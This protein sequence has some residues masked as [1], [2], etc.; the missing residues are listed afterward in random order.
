MKKRLFAILLC[1]AIPC[2]AAPLTVDIL[3]DFE[4]STDG[5]D[6]TDAIMAAA[7][8]GSIGAGVWHTMSDPEALTQGTTPYLEITTAAK[9]PIYTPFTVDGITYPA[10]GTRGLRA[11][12]SDNNTVCYFFDT[13]YPT[14]LSVGFFFRFNGPAINSSPRDLLS[15]VDGGG[16][17]QALQIYDQSSGNPY[18]HAHTGLGAGSDIEFLRAHWYWVTIYRAAAGQSMLV[19]F[20]DTESS[21]ALVGTSALGV[22]GGTSGVHWMD[23]GCRKYFSGGTQSVDFDNFVVLSAGTYPLGPGSGPDVQATATSIS[24]GTLSI[25]P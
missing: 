24:V 7:V 16:N 14:S 3:A 19:K 22:P 11:T 23:F 1:A 10:S 2:A 8:H 9:F 20:Y 15:F 21:Y 18:F 5:T 12:M 6:L 25:T 13:P 17:F 4:T